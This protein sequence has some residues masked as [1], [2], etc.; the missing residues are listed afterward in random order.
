MAR[1]VVPRDGI[2]PG[3]FHT[4]VAPGTSDCLIGPVPL[5]FASAFGGTVSSAV[6]HCF[7]TAGVTGSIPVPSTT[8]LPIILPAITKREG[9]AKMNTP[10][11]Y[12]PPK[13]NVADVSP[14]DDLR[15]A[16]RLSR[17]GAAILD[18]IIVGALIYTPLIFTGALGAAMASAMRSGN[19]LQ[20]WGVFLTGAGIV[21]CLLFI[22]W[23]VIT[24]RFVAANGQTIAKKLIGIKVVRSDGSR[25]TVAA[26]HL[27]AD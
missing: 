23:A 15:L 26:N 9:L 24:F 13:A 3:C 25:A 10:N 14:G 21:S 7:H 19:P 2:R 1:Y 20:F 18:S 4:A 17:L 27:D 6:E 22:G 8:S 5:D 12:A 16:S 11:A